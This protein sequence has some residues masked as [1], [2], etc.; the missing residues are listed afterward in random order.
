MMKISLIKRLK[1]KTDNLQEDS[2]KITLRRNKRK[3]TLPLMLRSRI[4]NMKR[5][6]SS[7]EKKE[8][9]TKRKSPD[10]HSKG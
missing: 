8:T 10:T 2:K 3:I 6:R 4:Q 1:P 7:M 9:V 5:R